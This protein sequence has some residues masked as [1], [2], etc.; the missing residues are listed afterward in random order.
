M[1]YMVDLLR[2]SG[3]GD[4]I[5]D[6]SERLLCGGDGGARIF[7]SFCNKD[8]VVRTSKDYH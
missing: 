3:P 5:S 1:F 8:Q 4:S 6:N 2:T 7:K